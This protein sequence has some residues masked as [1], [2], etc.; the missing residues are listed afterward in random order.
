[1]RTSRTRA[2]PRSISR[3]VRNGN[4]SFDKSVVVNDCS[5][6]RERGPCTFSWAYPAVTSVAIA[7]Q[8][9]CDRADAL[10]RNRQNWTWWKGRSTKAANLAARLDAFG[11]HMRTP[12]TEQVDWVMTGLGT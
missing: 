7:W 4:A 2:N 3:A 8:R 11:I 12:I 9:S 1:M 10:G 5:N 6:S